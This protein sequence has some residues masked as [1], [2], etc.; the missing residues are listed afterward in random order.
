MDMNQIRQVSASAGL[1]DGL[2]EQAPIIITGTATA[3]ASTSGIT[4]LRQALNKK[5]EGI[6]VDLDRH[7]RPRKRLLPRSFFSGDAI[8][9]LDSFYYC[10]WPDRDSIVAEMES[11]NWLLL[12][13]PWQSGK[14][15][16]LTALGLELRAKGY[17]V[18]LT[19]MDDKMVALANDKT[20]QEW[21]AAEDFYKRLIEKVCDQSELEPPEKSS[22]VIDVFTARK[23]VKPVIWLLDEAQLLNQM[24][25]Q[26]GYAVRNLLS[27]LR[28]A[29]RESVTR[30][31]LG[32][33]RL[34]SF[35]LCGLPRLAY[36][37]GDA[38]SRR[39]SYVPSSPRHCHDPLRPYLSGW[40]SPLSKQ[41]DRQR[42]RL[43]QQ[44]V[45]KMLDDYFRDRF[46]FCKTTFDG[47][48]DEEHH[49][50]AISGISKSIMDITS[51]HA[52]LVGWCCDLLQGTGREQGPAVRSFEH[53]RQLVEQGRVRSHAFNDTV[54]GKM[55]RV[56]A[57]YPDRVKDV[58]LQCIDSVDGSAGVDHL[59]TVLEAIDDGVLEVAG[60]RKVQLSSPLLLSTLLESCKF[61]PLQA[62]PAPT[63]SLVEVYETAIAFM[64]PKVFMRPKVLNASGQ[65]SEYIM[66]SQFFRGL[67]FIMEQSLYTPHKYHVF[68]EV[69]ES[70]ENGRRMKRMDGFMESSDAPKQGMEVQVGASSSE[71]REAVQ[72][73][74][75][76]CAYYGRLHRC[77][78]SY[79]FFWVGEGDPTGA[80]TVIKELTLLTE[81]QEDGTEIVKV[82]SGF[83]GISCWLE[84]N[85]N[86]VTSRKEVP[87]EFPTLLLSS[88]D[89]GMR[90]H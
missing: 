57:A 72:D 39:E 41:L 12:T 26:T 46:L 69:K 89:R 87:P 30:N 24:H 90:R 67:M 73:H 47:D 40:S 18:E 10:P 43:G 35:C 77:E 70:D 5:R 25:H 3:G 55:V 68:V 13:A 51:G 11:G 85:G 36:L 74:L 71:T 82:Q 88:L 64:N 2:S 76:R 33:Y 81:V 61:A 28:I 8:V 83:A 7:L 9:D 23:D 66:Q 59:D 17:L 45:A 42:W 48:E 65:P 84:D 37:I 56:V 1:G 75:K 78:M 44:Q 49:R 79:L 31:K 58:I 20:K 29:K 32:K 60:T 38:R 21:E 54:F 15:T 63:E 52:G 86:W 6:H 14:S 34:H 19:T 80:K 4:T 53:W 50:Q 16:L 27:S 62:L 22:E